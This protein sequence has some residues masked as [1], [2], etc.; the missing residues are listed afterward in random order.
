MIRIIGLIIAI[1]IFLTSLIRNTRV[2]DKY[3]TIKFLIIFFLMT[4]GVWIWYSYFSLWSTFFL[5]LISI[6]SFIFSRSIALDFLQRITNK[7]THDLGFEC[8]LHVIS[9][10]EWIDWYLGDNEAGDIEK[11]NFLNVE[12]AFTGEVYNADS[13]NKQKMIYLLPAALVKSS[14]QEQYFMI[15]HEISHHYLGHCKRTWYRTGWARF[16]ANFLIFLGG[17]LVGIGVKDLVSSCIARKLNLQQI[18]VQ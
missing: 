3:K 6:I 4:S 5:I 2:I 13:T 16:I 10:K 1:L 14:R 18:N 15:A 11:K 9:W 8:Y 12:T 17:G 7:L